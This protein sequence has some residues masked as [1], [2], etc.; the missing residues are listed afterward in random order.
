MFLKICLLG[1]MFW[2]QNN[3]LDNA[4]LFPGISFLEKFEK[5]MI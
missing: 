5:L 4:L 1:E 3:Q 2:R